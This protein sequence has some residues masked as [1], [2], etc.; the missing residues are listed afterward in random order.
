MPPAK[1]AAHPLDAR[2]PANQPAPV[3]ALLLGE[4]LQ[5]RG[6]SESPQDLGPT[7]Q[8]AGQAGLVVLFPYGAAILFNL[9]RDEERDF[10]KDFRA[11][12]ES[13]LRK[14]ELEEQ[15]LIPAGK[16][17]EGVTPEGLALADYS[18]SRLQVVATVLAR[19]VSLAYHETRIARAFDLIEPLARELEQHHGAKRLRESLRQIGGALL[20]QHRMTGRVEV[21]EKPDL[22]WE[23]PELERLFLNLENEYELDERDAALDRKLA[24]IGR[25]A[26]IVSNL[27]QNRRML[28]VEWYIVILILF[29]IVW[30]LVQFLLRQ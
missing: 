14:H 4:R 9:T 13:P 24:L 29:D 26:E 7:V 21:K 6:L 27:L 8:S 20:V 5:L 3:R 12:I 1:R 18:L 30:N 19:S 15:T 23:R 17:G 16:A 2:L 10:L 22:L 25:T 11:R 28:R